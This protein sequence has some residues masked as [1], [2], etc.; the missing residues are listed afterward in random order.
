VGFLGAYLNTRYTAIPVSLE[1]ANLWLVLFRPSE[2]LNLARICNMHIDLKICWNKK[3]RR[4]NFAKPIVTGIEE[5][6]VAKMMLCEGEEVNKVTRLTGL[7]YLVGE[8]EG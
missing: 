4:P 2:F 5:V 1:F 8:V 6:H 3:S 7:T